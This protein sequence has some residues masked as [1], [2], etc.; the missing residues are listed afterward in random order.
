MAHKLTLT[1]IA[2]LRAEDNDP[3]TRRMRRRA[4]RGRPTERGSRSTARSRW[5]RESAEAFA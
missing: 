1:V 4:R 3:E 2:Q 5:V